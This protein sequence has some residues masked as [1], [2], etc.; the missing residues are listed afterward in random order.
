MELTNTLHTEETQKQLPEGVIAFP[1]QAKVKEVRE[2]PDLTDMSRYSSTDE[3]VAAF[4][5]LSGIVPEPEFI[6]RVRELFLENAL[7]VD[8]VACLAAEVAAAYEQTAEM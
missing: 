3:A 8:Y 1:V 5:E 7:S 4:V 6:G 2:I